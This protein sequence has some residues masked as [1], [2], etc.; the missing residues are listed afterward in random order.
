MLTAMADELRIMNEQMALLPHY[1]PYQ[2]SVVA[3]VDTLG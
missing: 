2:Y 1:N 3:V